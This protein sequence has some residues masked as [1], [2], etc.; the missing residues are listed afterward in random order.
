MKK[1]MSTQ[2]SSEIKKLAEVKNRCKIK[3]QFPFDVNWCESA[4]LSSIF[5]LI[6]PQQKHSKKKNHWTKINQKE[7]DDQK[8]LILII[9]NKNENIC[10]NKQKQTNTN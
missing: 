2:G 5:I 10:E 1:K 4:C 6:I 3:N 9:R 7:L 8:D